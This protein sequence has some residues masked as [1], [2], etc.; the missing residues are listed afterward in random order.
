MKNN[1]IYAIY[2]RKSR[3]DL[4]AEARG[5]GETLARH[6][7]ALT[8]LANRRGLSVAH[9]Y[10]EIVSG[11]SIA[12]RPQMQALLAAV[13]RGEYAG[14]I[15]NDA[16]RLARGDSI[17][18]GIIKQAFYSTGTLIITPLKDYDPRNVSD[19]DYFDFSL[20]F[21]RFE[22][23]ISTRRLQTGRMRSAAEG[24]YVGSR[25]IYG[26][27]RVKRPDRAGWTL[28][29][30]PET[31]EIVRT[32]FQWYAYGDGNGE[33]IGS[34]SIA[35][36]LNAIGIK[37]SRGKMFDSGL[38][39]NILRNRAYIGETSWNKKTQRVQSRGAEKTV[40]RVKSDN[41]IIVENAHPAIVDRELF[42]TVQAMFATHAKLPRKIT[43][44]I[45]NPFSG[46]LKCSICGRTLQRRGPD[47]YNHCSLRCPTQGCPTSGIYIPIL[48]DAVLDC[49]RGWV[50][51]Y[52][53]PAPEKKRDD[54]RSNAIRAAEKQIETIHRQ[55][56]SL[57]DFLEQGIYS[58][59]D[60][61]RRRAE[62][63]DRLQAAQAQLDSI[64]S[65]PTDAE[66]IVA[67]LP[68]IQSVLDAYPLADDPA[69][70]NAL[71]RSVIDH[72]DYSK[73]KTC[74]RNENPADYLTIR[75]YPR[76]DARKI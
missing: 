43:D 69:E 75:V 17:D 34:T 64:R 16:D 5:E 61:I 42:D 67:E 30:D 57:H 71:L 29:P 14:V 65:T 59:Q 13:E 36:R 44:T 20:F 51:A 6:R 73:T 11:D 66:L 18:Q 4:D 52:A 47:N 62:L 70:K 26:Y 48:E 63:T 60:F 33:P 8:D 31:A 23:K 54:S 45:K 49:L 37:S 24:N 2:L 25:A 55:L 9:V 7:R 56:D 15:V 35:N 41:P 22:Y 28:E 72:I 68:Q 74:M 53:D 38:V 46:L 10:E 50:T 3:A 12:S 27:K 76:I 39:R 40:K 19:E 1:G 32:I 21:A 58:P